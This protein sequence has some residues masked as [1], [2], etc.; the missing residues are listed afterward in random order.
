MA[1]LSLAFSEIGLSKMIADLDALT[2]RMESMEAGMASAAAAANGTRGLAS[3]PRA[4]DKLP[5]AAGSIDAFNDELERLKAQFT[6]T[7]SAIERA[8]IGPQIA[9]LERQVESANSAIPKATKSMGDSI[10]E[11]ASQYAAAFG[12]AAVATV[13]A[14]SKESVSAFMD[15]EDGLASLESITGA[16]GEQMAYLG[17]QAKTMGLEV[18]G[19]ATATLKAFE[20][21]GSARPEL[22]KDV[23]AL[24]E[25]TDQAITFSQA[26]GLDLPTAATALTDALNQFGEPASAAAKY[27]DVLAAGANYGAATIPQATEALL[28]FGTGAD[29]FN[30][31]IEESIA[32]VQLFSL[33]GLKGAEAGTAMR[34]IL[35]KME[36]V[37][38]LG[39]EA[40][41]GLERAGVNLEL[42]T[43]QS[44]PLIDRLKEMGKVFNDETAPIK[45]FGAE[46]EIAAQ[47]LFGNLDKYADLEK[48]MHAVGLAQSQAATNTKTLSFA[49]QEIRNRVG[50]VMIELGEAIAPVL[51]M[52][53]DGFVPAF[54]SAKKTLE[55]TFGPIRDIAFEIRELGKN[56]GLSTIEGNGFVI[57][58]DLLGE[59]FAQINMPLTAFYKALKITL[60]V[61]NWSIV[62]YNDTR[63]AIHGF[64]DSIPFAV[65]ALDG[66]GT[67]FMQ[68][69]SPINGLIDA[70]HELTGLFSGGPQGLTDTQNAYKGMRE[71]IA[72]TAA[73]MGATKD[74]I[75]AF[76]KTLKLSDYAT[77]SMTD[78][79]AKLKDEFNA[80]RLAGYRAAEAA[81]ELEMKL[82]GD[83][84]KGGAKAGIEGMG[85]A[86]KHATMQLDELKSRLLD[87]KIV[88]LTLEVGTGAVKDSA[89]LP[90]RNLEDFTKVLDAESKKSM[91][92]LDA[93]E[94]HLNTFAEGVTQTFAG[95]KDGMISMMT[96]MG[97]SIAEGIGY[98]M[99]AG[100]GIGNVVKKALQDMAVQIPK[101]AGMALLNAAAF[102]ANAAIALPL[103]IAGA[104]LLG[105]SGILS[106]VFKG[107]AA[108]R[109][110]LSSVPSV[111]GGS[112]VGGSVDRRGLESFTGGS[113]GQSMQTTIVIE[114]AEGIKL[115]GWIEKEQKR[116][117]RKA[118]R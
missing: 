12:A 52:I 74:E 61:I 50:V 66:L 109:D 45:V 105:L 9:D 90:M 69:L 23:T 5:A 71:T 92:V 113:G 81:K 11:F 27:M 72:A 98:A 47:S 19:G 29:A 60:E 3:I 85:E 88:D 49:F 67:V 96:D 65:D 13:V 102:P 48:N 35:L 87:Q 40:L 39:K 57:A 41:D 99:A 84:G 95:L 82:A 21:I 38:G 25:L 10:G 68:M 15:F 70:Y 107:S 112:S 108:K 8:H 33:Y 22:L 44:K 20:L 86:A 89:D 75:A 97:Y 37:K 55:A 42:V 115:M 78:A 80:F 93:Q 31:S 16:N 111:G 18:Q 91:A 79:A 64:T 117:N 46:N 104:G 26:A 43:D 110:A 30:V 103:A 116:R 2:A 36:G 100:G 114:G 51:R 59:A 34:N 63:D 14:F 4:T 118:T 101:M 1:E 83:K 17:E 6:A 7:G 24:T 53:A 76:T 77:L 28:R 73:E 106:G 32:G 62:A 58:V 94:A 54:E 56:L